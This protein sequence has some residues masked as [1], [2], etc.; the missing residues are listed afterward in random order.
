MPVF[1][2]IPYLVGRLGSGVRVSASFRF[3]LG[4]VISGENISR[5]RVMSRIR[6]L[7]E[8]NKDGDRRNDAS[9]QLPSSLRS[10]S[11]PPRPSRRPPQPNVTSVPLD[12]GRSVTSQAS[13]AGPG[14]G[15]GVSSALAALMMILGRLLQSQQP[16]APSS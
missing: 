4:G 13:T 6:C 11:S 2:K 15:D 3:S 7:T 12:V 14:H 5:G 8:Y 9:T 16:A 10:H 1:R